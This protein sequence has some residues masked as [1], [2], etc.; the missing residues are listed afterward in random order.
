[1]TVNFENQPDNKKYEQLIANEKENQD[2]IN[3]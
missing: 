1:M 2:F 3:N